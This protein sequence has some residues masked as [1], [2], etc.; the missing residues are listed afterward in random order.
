MNPYPYYRAK[1][2]C[3]QLVERS[4]IPFTIQRATQFH[5]FVARIFG[6]QRRLPFFIS[7]DVSDQPIAVDE[8]ADRLVELV[9]A[10]PSGKVAD[11]GG[12]EQ[13]PLRT[14]IDMWQAAHGTSKRVVTLKLW[15][16]IIRSFKAGD[17]MTPLPGYGRETFAEFAARHAATATNER[18]RG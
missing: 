15:G 13:L 11:I 12:P 6:L 8:V 5:E 3:E 17:H 4:G 1:Y 14:L 2:E 7:L 10:G 18:N 16:R 9:D